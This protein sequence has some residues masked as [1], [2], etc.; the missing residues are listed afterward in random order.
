MEILKFFLPAWSLAHHYLSSARDV[1]WSIL[2]LSHLALAM[3]G[4]SV[5]CAFSGQ[6]SQGSDLSCQ[7]KKV[8]GAQSG[9][10]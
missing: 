6:G 1:P 4:N 9:W 2:L 10:V 7:E 8:L 3:L 5:D